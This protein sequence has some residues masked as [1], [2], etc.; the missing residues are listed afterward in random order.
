MGF[1]NWGA[2]CGVKSSGPG[3]TIS[4]IWF[5]RWVVFPCAFLFS[6][7]TVS[8]IPCDL[9]WAP[10]GIVNFLRQV[11][12]VLR[13]VFRE[14][15]APVGGRR[16]LAIDF[17]VAQVLTGRSGSASVAPSACSC[18]AIPT[19]SNPVSICVRTASLESFLLSIFV[20]AWAL[21]G[22]LS[23]AHQ[24]STR[25]SFHWWRRLLGLLHSRE[26]FCCV[27]CA[28]IVIGT[29]PAIALESPD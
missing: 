26:C 23:V 8:L 7:P 27:L 18:G 12:L 14:V 24:L 1:F 21:L 17:F 19:Q 29:R 5:P 9:C 16:L 3:Q 22:L 13:L 15:P 11:F 28:G 4:S 25:F 10:V 2:K 6:A 20:S